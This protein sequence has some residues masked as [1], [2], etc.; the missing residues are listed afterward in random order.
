MPSRPILQACLKI[1]APSSSV[2]LLKT[3]PTLRL[4]TSRARR[5]LRSPGGRARRSSPSLH[6]VE[7]VQ[8][9]PADGAAPVQGVE[10]RDAVR[11]AD[12]GLALERERLGGS[13]GDRGIASTPVVAPARVKRRTESPCRWT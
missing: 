13:S 2:R 10:D 1:V 8:H 11:P 3:M 6:G 9:G 4:T 5:F 12:H 7:G